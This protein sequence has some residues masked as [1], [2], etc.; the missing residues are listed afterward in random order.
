MENKWLE[1]AK[2]VHAIAETGLTFCKNE[3]DIERYEQLK[4][5]SFE[6]L[7]LIGKSDPVV[8]SS[9]FEHQ[10][11]YQTPKVDVRGVVIVDGKLLMVREKVDGCWSLPGG[12]ADVG[13]TPYENAI[14]EVW[15]ESGLKVKPV[16]LLSVMD[17]KCHN[18]P[19]FPWYCYKIFVLCEITGGELKAG[20]ETLDVAFFS[21]NDLPRLSEERITSGQIDIIYDLV[22]NEGSVWCD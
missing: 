7:G 14:K 12:W 15:E 18:H 2:K 17:K 21:R 19:P 6:M 9:L 8:V 20:M 4:E 1:F 10:K 16:R 3:Y 11:G 13:L 5:I 22:G